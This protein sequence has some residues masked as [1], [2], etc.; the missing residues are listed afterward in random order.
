MTDPNVFNPKDTTT[1]ETGDDR[2]ASTTIMDWLWAAKIHYKAAAS[3]RTRVPGDFAQNAQLA[4]SAALID[5]A[6]SLQF[7]A[8]QMGRRE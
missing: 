6:R 3:A 1:I 8:T 4:T 2:D 5:I 7:I